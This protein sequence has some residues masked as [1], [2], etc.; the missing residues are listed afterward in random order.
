[1]G[2]A[3]ELLGSR[4]RWLRVAAADAMGAL[5]SPETVTLLAERLGDPDPAVRRSVV[6]A[7]LRIGSPAARPALRLATRDADREVRVYAFEALK[8]IPGS[9]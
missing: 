7:L 1:V 6:I 2:P 9:T 8:R 5:A 3:T 4:E